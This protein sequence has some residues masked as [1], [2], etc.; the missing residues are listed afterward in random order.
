MKSVLTLSFSSMALN[1]A[2]S[3]L[4]L[5]CIRRGSIKHVAYNIYLTNILH[6]NPDSLIGSGGIIPMIVATLGLIFIV[7][8]VIVIKNEHHKC[9]NPITFRIALYSISIVL[10]VNVANI[11]Q[12]AAISGII[13][14]IAYNPLGTKGG[15][16]FNL[17]DVLIY[18]VMPIG[19][20]A[21]VSVSASMLV[22]RYRSRQ[23]SS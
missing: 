20:L 23:K 11:I 13:D 15:Y 1:L 3:V 9:S 10:G 14:Y 22:A 5:R 4:A 18:L 12:S 21:A 7:Y 16:A 8:A 19:L 2:L 17:G 6:A